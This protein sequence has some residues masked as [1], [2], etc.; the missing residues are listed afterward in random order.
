MAGP[1]YTS[2][3][4]FPGLPT[5]SSPVGADLVV[6]GDSANS[7]EPSQCTI[8]QLLGNVGGTIGTYINF[9]GSATPTN[10][11]SKNISSITN[12]GAIAFTYTLNFSVSF[13][14]TYYK[15]VGSSNYSAAYY[16]V[17]FIAFNTGNC[18]FSLI[19]SNGSGG[20]YGAQT[21]ILILT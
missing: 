8:T 21:S 11:S 12:S 20:G 4:G 18:T 6:I 16:Y 3:I 15:P 10:N 19:Y 5:K 2:A 14:N 9:T 7:N 13:A 17:G 1:F